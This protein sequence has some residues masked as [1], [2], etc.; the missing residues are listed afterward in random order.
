[1]SSGQAVSEEERGSASRESGAPPGASAGEDG[2]LGDRDLPAPGAGAVGIGEKVVSGYDGTF[3]EAVRDAVV[4][5][6]A[7]M[8]FNNYQSW[9]KKDGK[10]PVK[11]K[12]GV[13]TT[14]G[15]ESSIWKEAMK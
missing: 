3:L 8:T 6:P 2:G 11:A 14:Q 1:M 13:S 15:T 9:R 10:R 7:L 12:D 5:Q 4:P